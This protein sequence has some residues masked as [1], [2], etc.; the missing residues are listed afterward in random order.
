MILTS[1]ALAVILSF[2]CLPCLIKCRA[3]PVVPPTA[4]AS[5][6]VLPPPK[7]C[8][9]A[10]ALRCITA[11]LLL[12]FALPSIPC[13][14]PEHTPPHSGT[15]SYFTSCIFECS[16]FDRHS[17]L[18]HSTPAAVS[19][20]LYIEQRLHSA[21][22]HALPTSSAVSNKYMQADRRANSAAAGKQGSLKGLSNSGTILLAQGGTRRATPA[23]T[24]RAAVFKRLSIPAGL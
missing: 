17:P 14:T 1:I 8:L 23:A 21:S 10:A 7:Y 13:S 22:S 6:C 20:L 24:G 4:S 18:L 3:I 16:R 15:A 11:T 2:H 5:Y 19:V 9:R 12:P